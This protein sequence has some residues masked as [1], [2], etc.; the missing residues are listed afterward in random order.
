M[1][2]TE[3]EDEIEVTSS[4]SPTNS[5]TAAIDALTNIVITT[6]AAFVS[7]IKY[8]FFRLSVCFCFFLYFLF[9]QSIIISIRMSAITEKN[10]DL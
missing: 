1:L 7:S 10:N 4:S 6:A 9:Y 5:S 8:V 3:K 2:P